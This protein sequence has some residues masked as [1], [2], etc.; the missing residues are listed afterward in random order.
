MERALLPSED[1]SFLNVLVVNFLSRSLIFISISSPLAYNM[2][3]MN[4]AADDF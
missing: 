2:K 1:L 3:Y 4:R